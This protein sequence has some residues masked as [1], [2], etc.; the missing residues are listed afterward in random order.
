MALLPSVN[1]AHPLGCWRRRRVPDWIVF[2]KLVDR[3]GLDGSYTKHAD[4]RVSAA[5]LRTRRHEWFRAGA[6]T[7]LESIVI[8][9]FDAIIG[10][11]LTHLSIDGCC[12]K[13]PCGGDNAGSNPTDRGKSGQKRSLRTEGHGIPIGLVLDGANRHDSP[14]LAPTLDCLSRFG[15]SLSER[16]RIDLDAG[17]DS[18]KTR[19]L[20]TLLGCEWKIS[21]KERF[22]EI[23]LIRRWMIERTNSWHTRGFGLLQIGLDRTA[24]VQSAWVRLAN[25]III[26][27]RLLKE[28]W[29]RCRWE[30]RPVKQYDCR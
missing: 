8:D 13:V 2:T 17:Y 5:T 7:A 11:D 29:T 3:L 24:G 27:K 6:F 14:L 22:I 1:N 25:A 26:V 28:A 18:A 30:S 4:E 9:S 20:L 23:N 21:P 12:V 15:F 16:I 19:E 10:L